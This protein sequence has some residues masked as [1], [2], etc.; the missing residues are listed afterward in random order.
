MN[1]TSSR[2]VV[3]VVGVVAL[4]AV[5]GGVAVA[6]GTVTPTVTACAAPKSGLMRWL[7]KGK[8]AASEH[9]L[10]W[11]AVGPRGARGL[12][13]ARGAAGATGAVGPVGP[14]GPSNSYSA[15]R[16]SGPSSLTTGAT[17]VATLSGLPA[18]AYSISATT[19]I[20]GS[21]SATATDVLC[22]LHAEADQSTA[23]AYV[24]TVAGATFDT[25]LPLLL[26]HT[27]AGVGAVTLACNKDL[28]SLAAVSNTRIV[29]T[30]VGSESHVDVTG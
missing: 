15:F 3:T 24:G 30:R 2:A 22:T 20:N 5:A 8:C 16:A 18:G 1:I 6:T 7:P 28:T 12:T 9:K 19:E 26:T 10:A 17:T 11:A 23:G 4:L 13:G 27:F 25:Q 29:A 14:V 21:A